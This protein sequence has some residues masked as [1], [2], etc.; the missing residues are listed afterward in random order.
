[1]AEGEGYPLGWPRDAGDATHSGSAVGPKN[2][3]AASEGA[4]VPLARAEGQ[5]GGCGVAWAWESWARNG[6]LSFRLA[7]LGESVGPATDATEAAPQRLS[8]H[9]VLWVAPA[10]APR[11]RMGRSSLLYGMR[12]KEYLV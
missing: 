6:P 2:V 4:G 8:S 9:V 11:T 12:S 7:V 1:M 3:P 10:E 5:D